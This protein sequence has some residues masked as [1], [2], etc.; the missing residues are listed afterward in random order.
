M[1]PSPQ[2]TN[3]NNENGQNLNSSKNA[4]SAPPVAAPR[5]LIRDPNAGMQ[6]SR[7]TPP[8]NDS[9]NENTIQR[10]NHQQ[11]E[12]RQGLCFVLEF[13]FVI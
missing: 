12:Q 7:N 11:Q 8:R 6:N 13:F 3:G 5:Q 10:P 9:D 4:S 1:T 2:T